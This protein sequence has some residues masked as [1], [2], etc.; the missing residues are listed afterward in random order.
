MY[1]LSR[2]NT[3]CITSPEHTLWL[4]QE[5]QRVIEPNIVGWL[6]GL[7]LYKTVS[8]LGDVIAIGATA[9]SAIRSCT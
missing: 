8:V 3:C 1:H 9:A 4:K 2:T 5:I 6:V 7:Q